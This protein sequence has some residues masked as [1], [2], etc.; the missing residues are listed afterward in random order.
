LTYLYQ[1]F[2]TLPLEFDGIDADV[3]QDLKPWIA[4][5]GDGVSCGVQLDNGPVARG[6]E[7]F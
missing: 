7:N 3:Y 1:G 5:D 6:Q 2:E 4:S